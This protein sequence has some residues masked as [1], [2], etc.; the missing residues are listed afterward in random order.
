MQPSVVFQCLTSPFDCSN[1]SLRP[2]TA[3]F[4]AACQPVRCS[5]P[6]PRQ[7]R[8][9]PNLRPQTVPSQRPVSLISPSPS[10]VGTNPNPRPHPSQL[11]I[12]SRS[13][14]DQL[15]IVSRS[16]HAEIRSDHDRDLISVSVACQLLVEP[17]RQV[18]LDGVGHV[19]VPPTG[20]PA[21]WAAWAHV[22]LG[23]GKPADTR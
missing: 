10:Q 6:S 22:K 21:P 23:A 2:Q 13:A 11:Q 4:P 9:K 1:R 8:P 7:A 14:Q 16:D 17:V 5:K 18:L 15:K 20:L 12:M 19:P 3:P